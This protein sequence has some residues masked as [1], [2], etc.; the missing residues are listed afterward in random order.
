MIL[1][2]FSACSDVNSNGNDD[3]LSASGTIAAKDINVAPEIGGKVIEVL[4]EE[5]NVVSA[6]DVLLRV[7][8]ALIQAQYTQAAT[9]VDAARAT[10]DTAKA[11]L[12]SAQIQH[13]LILQGVHLQ[14][15]ETRTTAWSVPT[16]EEIEIPSWYYVKDER[17]Q[18]LETEVQ[19]A[20]EDLEEQLVH[21]EKERQNVSNGDFIAA[22]TYLAEV[23]TT[24][25]IAALTLAQ[26]LEAADQDVLQETAQEAY[27]A[28]LANLES[29]QLDYD[30][31]LTSSAVN[32]LLK[33]RAKATIAQARLDNAKDQLIFLRSGEESLQVVASLAGVEQAR[34]AVNQAEANLAQ[35]EAALQIV[36]IQLEKTVARAP[37]SGV[38]L[39]LNLSVG[40]LIGAGST[41]MTIAQLDNVDLT[42]YI[43]EDKYGTVKLG[44]EVYISVDSFPGSTFIGTV[45]HI[46]NEAEFTPSNVQTVEG[47]KTTVYA[48]K[49]TV[50]NQDQ[51]LKPGMPADVDFT[52][53]P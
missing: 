36:A 51:K 46:S 52:I 20:Q 18:A 17:I 35:A 2:F 40:E 10:V 9:A 27:D 41:T 49:I 22:E 28:A 4:V 16:S 23:Q 34:T 24:F 31:L 6:G 3:S 26:T 47:R 21:L 39:S 11:Q 7:D 19:A 25:N 13:E 44:Q 43:P 1:A 32:D 5:G 38:I 37:I 14:E 53:I 30:R 8:D 48:V 33:A 42:V 45:M 29:A 50:P 15:I 12:V